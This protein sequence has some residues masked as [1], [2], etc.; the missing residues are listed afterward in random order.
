MSDYLQSK[1]A[2]NSTISL[3][4]EQG[5]DG[6]TDLV[7]KATYK[8]KQGNVHDVTMRTVVSY[9]KMGKVKYVTKKVLDSAKKS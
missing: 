5:K 6:F 8:D 1:G 9:K 4:T 2:G 3:K 7:W